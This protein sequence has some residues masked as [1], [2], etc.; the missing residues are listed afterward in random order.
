[1]SVTTNI[2]EKPKES[3]ES[4]HKFSDNLL[5]DPKPR[6][7]MNAM[8]MEAMETTTWRFW[9]ALV[10]LGVIVAVCLVGAWGYLIKEGLGVAGTN[11]IASHSAGIGSGL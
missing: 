5:L 6:G 4:K 2:G 10:I 9:V 1:M 8:V 7:E 11:A 3:G